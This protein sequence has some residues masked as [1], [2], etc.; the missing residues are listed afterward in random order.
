L[1]LKDKEKKI[2]FDNTTLGIPYMESVDKP[3]P[4]NIY[5]RRETWPIGRIPAGVLFLTC[6]I[7]VQGDRLECHVVGW[8][9]DKQSW[10][11]DYRILY[12]D[13]DNLKTWEA[14]NELLDRTWDSVCGRFRLPI[15]VSAIDTGYRTEKVYEFVR[16]FFR[17]EG[18]LAV[19]G[20]DRIGTPIG[21]PSITEVDSKGRSFKKGIHLWPVGVD[22]LKTDLYDRLALRQDPD[23]G[24]FPAHY[25][26]F[27]EYDIEFFRQL[28]AESKRLKVTRAGRRSHV[29]VKDHERNEVL[30]TWIYAR[31]AA[32]K[33]GLDRFDDKEWQKIENSIVISTSNNEPARQSSGIAEKTV[34]IKRK[35]NAGFW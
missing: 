21:R 30:D 7:D 29:W 34:K 33:F 23:T 13:T 12:G 27:P 20:D 15:Q 8:S 31:A 11:I 32:C 16:K 10:S 24:V 17:S 35:S 18:I 3:D 9:R 1:A 6:G 22:Y 19:K 25:C 4:Q 2:A 14:L 5:D 26:H 28:T